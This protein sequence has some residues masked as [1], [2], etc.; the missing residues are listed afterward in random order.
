MA[1]K[2][3][4]QLP[5][6]ASAALNMLLEVAAPSATPAN[7]SQQLTIT[8]LQALLI[9]SGMIM[10]WKGTI[11]TIPSGWQLCNGTNG[12]PDL[13]NQFVVCANADSGGAAKT[14]I[15][16]AALQAGGT[17]THAHSVTDN[18]HQHTVSA[19]DLSL[20]GFPNGTLFD[21]D[22]NSGPVLDL[23]GVTDNAVTGI[24]INSATTVQPFFALAYIMK[25]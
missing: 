6:A 8:Q 15:T 13:R 20:T 22:V 5:A 4:P 2:T 24:V 10:L 14:T 9:P 25:L 11:A 1:T 3:I 21:G 18:G 19:S 7:Q 17:T 16:G 23:T 12:T